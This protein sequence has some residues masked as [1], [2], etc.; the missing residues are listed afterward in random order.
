MPVDGAAVEPLTQATKVRVSRRSDAPVARGNAMRAPTAE[1]RTGV[2]R[3]AAEHAEGVGAVARQG[4]K[5]EHR[6]ASGARAAPA[7]PLG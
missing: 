7:A 3:A 2:M 1:R 5:N 6:A 4:A